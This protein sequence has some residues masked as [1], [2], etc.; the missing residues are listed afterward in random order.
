MAYI[1]PSLKIKNISGKGRVRVATTFIHKDTVILVEEPKTKVDKVNEN[2][3]FEC[4]YKIYQNKEEKQW[5]KLYP[6][7]INKI[8]EE[9]KKVATIKNMVLKEWLLNQYANQ[10]SL[11]IAKYKSNAFNM[12]NDKTEEKPCILY[13]GAIFNHSCDPN[14]IFSFTDNKMIFKTCKD[15]NA[16]EELQVNYIHT[17]IHKSKEHRQYRLLNQYNFLCSCS[18]CLDTQKPSQG[19]A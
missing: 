10:L 8:D 12:D 17:D 5:S 4:I 14:V 15:V 19:T 7:E 11:D 18:K 16:N 9:I 3:M 2:A 6:S 13:S 1:H